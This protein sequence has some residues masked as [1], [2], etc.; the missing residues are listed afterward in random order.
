MNN[1]CKFLFAAVYSFN[2]T[3]ALAGMSGNSGGL[4]HT[5]HV[6]PLSSVPLPDKK[7]ILNYQAKM[8][9]FLWLWSKST[10]PKGFDN[11]EHNNSF[12]R[13][14]APA[15]LTTDLGWS[16]QVSRIR[17]CRN[18]LELFPM[19]LY[20]PGMSLNMNLGKTKPNLKVKDE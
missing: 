2:S 18:T 1:I 20:K 12:L 13:F 7:L 16:Q 9:T 19:V 14:L 3:G 17:F 6:V 15:P 5:P 4:R 8:R 11:R 10:Q